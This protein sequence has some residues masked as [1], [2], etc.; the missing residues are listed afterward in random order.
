MYLSE[1]KEF[2]KEAGDEHIGDVC[3]T[4]LEYVYSIH[5]VGDFISSN[6][7]RISKF[8]RNSKRL[9][10]SYYQKSL[11]IYFNSSENNKYERIVKYIKSKFEK[12]I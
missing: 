2:C 5:K 1:F 9:I 6:L 10:K 4:D 11:K 3:S 7:F 8:D 12:I